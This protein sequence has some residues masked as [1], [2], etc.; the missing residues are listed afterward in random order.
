MQFRYLVPLGPKY[1]AT[2]REKNLSA[3]VKNEK[4][5]MRYYES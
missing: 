2:L 3:T 1:S 4:N 5:H